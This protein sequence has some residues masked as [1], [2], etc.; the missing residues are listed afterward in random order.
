[1]RTN[2]LPVWSALEF[3]LELLDGHA[4]PARGRVHVEVVRVLEQFLGHQEGASVGSR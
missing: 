3:E 4:K 2:G 1:M